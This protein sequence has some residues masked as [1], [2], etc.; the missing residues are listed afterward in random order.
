M[1]I[2][3]CVS[4][5]ILIAFVGG[6]I[7]GNRKTVK[8]IVLSSL[9]YSLTNFRGN[10]LREM[11]ANGHDVIAVAPDNDEAVKRELA[12]SGIDFRVLPME[13]AGTNPIAD[14]RLLLS[15]IW[16][17]LQERPQL[18]LAYTQK[19][20]VYG[21]LASRIANV[22]RYFALMSGLGHVF[23]PGSTASPIVRNTLKHL[24][25][26]AVRWARA[27]FVFN[28]DDRRDMLELGIIKR[29]QS[30]IQV[31]GSG[32]DVSK[33]AQMRLPGGAPSFLM[34]AR[35]LRN[36]GIIEF[37]EAARTVS[38]KHPDCRF[39][40][41]GHL[42]EE[43]PEGISAADIERFE[44]E[45]PVR[46][47]PGTS[48]VR[49]YLAD[50]S[51]FVLP[52]YY[53][54]G[55]PRTILEAMATGR[56]VITTDQPGCRDPIEDGRNGIIVEPRSAE[57]LAAAMEKLAD[58]PDLISA[59]GQRSRD[60]AVEKYSDIKVNHQL[61]REM[62]LLSDRHTLEYPSHEALHENAAARGTAS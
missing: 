41:L 60:I 48:D 13:R 10:L 52:S 50:A 55:L 54:E 33:F 19:P 23:S 7:E 11:R 40:I 42:D 22:P 27:I 61:L 8:V 14:L 31:P 26:M 29:D 51:V 4:G 21:G 24:Y 9:A 37:L 47:I 16:L 39:S 49:H 28:A 44:R 32:V 38:D 6:K 17:M 53:R 62:D 43:N 35:L 1:P 56:G 58:N 3:W 20:I 46:F 5:P 18:V 36:K 2:A 34:I 57:A 25:R 59:M 15:Y 30:V 12:R 45:Y